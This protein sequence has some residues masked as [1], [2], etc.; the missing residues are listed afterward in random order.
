MYEQANVLQISGNDESANPRFRCSV[1]DPFTSSRRRGLGT[2][3][4]LI[5]YENRHMTCSLGIARDP[6][7]IEEDVLLH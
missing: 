5:W 6:L 4:L 7:P 2:S 3:L 1:R